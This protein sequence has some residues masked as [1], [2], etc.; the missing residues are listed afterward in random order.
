MKITLTLWCLIFG[1]THGCFAQNAEKL[2]MSGPDVQNL[3]LG[4]WSTQVQYAPTS[5][6]PKGGTG[7]GTEIW[8]PGPGDL[9]VVEEH[10]EKNEKG[11][12]EGLGVAWWDVKAQG[13]RFV[14]C[15]NSN[16]D[17]CYVSKEVAKWDGERLAWKEELEQSGTKRVYSEVFQDISPTSF[18]QLLGEGDS[19]ASL[20]TT[21]TIHAT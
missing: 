20:K 11:N 8:R 10:R 7:E 6:M 9:S 4:K 1:F 5:D 12:Y 21:V 18:T 15:D 14:W 19:E 2:K 3:M 17:G 16:P 13:Q